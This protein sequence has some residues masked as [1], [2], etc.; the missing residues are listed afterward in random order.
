MGRIHPRR[1]GIAAHMGLWLNKP[2]IGCG[3][4]YFIGQYSEPEPQ[5]GAYSNL[6]DHKELIGVVLRTKNNVKPVFIS[7]GHLMDL[8]SAVQITLACTGKY[9]LPEP[10][11]AAHNAA[12]KFDDTIPDNMMLI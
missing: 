6:I 3:K 10:I 7:P 8:P 5:K 2:T 11:R 12:G 1:I 4:T 9:R